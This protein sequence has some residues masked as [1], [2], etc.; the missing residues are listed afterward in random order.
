M[1]EALLLFPCTSYNCKQVGLLT[2]F[3][4]LHRDVYRLYIQ[5]V[6]LFDLL[7]SPTAAAA[8][9]VVVADRMVLLFAPSLLF[10]MSSFNV[11]RSLEAAEQTKYFPFEEEMYDEGD[12]PNY[13]FIIFFFIWKILMIKKIIY[14]IK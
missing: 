11:W 4:L 1:E 5:T 3:T 13:I 9:V 12:T 10:L 7:F 6:T 8:V 2:S 14:K